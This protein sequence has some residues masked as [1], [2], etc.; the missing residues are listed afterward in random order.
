MQAISVRAVIV[1]ARLCVCAGT[2]LSSATT[3]EAVDW[4][5]EFG[6][7]FSYPPDPGGLWG[8][9]W[10]DTWKVTCVLDSATPDLDPVDTH[11]GLYEVKAWSFEIAD[12]PLTTTWFGPLHFMNDGWD[13]GR[14]DALWVDFAVKPAPSHPDSF[15]WGMELIDAFHNVFSSDALPLRPPPVELFVQEANLHLWEPEPPYSY[16]VAWGSVTYWTPEPATALFLALG[17]VAMMRRTPSGRSQ[18]ANE[19]TV[20]QISGPAFAVD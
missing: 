18:S 20:L 12:R 10:D 2:V 1:A 9:E 15:V 4:T 17:G 16:L 11:H 7:R 5:Y 14:W 8:I 6:G 19:R 3:A 13:E